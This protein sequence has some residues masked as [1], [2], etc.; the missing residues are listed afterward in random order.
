M[1]RCFRSFPVGTTVGNIQ[2]GTRGEILHPREGF[3]LK[4][5]RCHEDK[6]RE[7]YSF[8]VTFYNRAELV[9]SVILLCS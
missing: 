9:P 1:D 2:D 7:K 3:A 5:N 8:L 6:H 4:A